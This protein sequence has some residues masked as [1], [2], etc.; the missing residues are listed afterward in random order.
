[1]ENIP[2]N[3]DCSCSVCE[4]LRAEQEEYQNAWDVKAWRTACGIVNDLLFIL[5]CAAL[6]WFFCYA[7]VG[8]AHAADKCQDPA[9]SLELKK[10]CYQMEEACQQIGCSVSVR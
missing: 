6:I 1:M 3:N 9:L 4:V 5:F 10:A 2:H 7:F 8:K